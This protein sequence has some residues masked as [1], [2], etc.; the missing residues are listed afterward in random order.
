VPVFERSTE[1][2]RRVLDTGKPS[3]PDAVGAPLFHALPAD[4]SD[5]PATTVPLYALQRPDGTILGYAA[6]DESEQ[7]AT[8]GRRSERPIC[9]VW[10]NPLSVEL[11][12]E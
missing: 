6:G 3:T 9:R 8:V 2:G 10:M 11:P 12:R 5:P 4:T 1:N 7:Q